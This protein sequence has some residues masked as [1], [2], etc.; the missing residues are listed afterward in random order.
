MQQIFRCWS[1]WETHSHLPAILLWN[2]SGFHNYVTD[3]IMSFI[4][5]YR[6]QLCELVQEIRD[7][8]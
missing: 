3:T 1:W 4:K 8:F 5:Q 7:S 2:Q 6:P